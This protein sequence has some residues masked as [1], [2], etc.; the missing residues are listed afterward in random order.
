MIYDYYIDY[1]HLG[2]RIDNTRIVLDKLDDFKWSDYNNYNNGY[3]YGYYNDYYS[4][5][6]TRATETQTDDVRA[7]KVVRGGSR[8]NVQ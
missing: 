2:G 4:Y 6:K 8:F 1:Y 3:G 5:A 7:G